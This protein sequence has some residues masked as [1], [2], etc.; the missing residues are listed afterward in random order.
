MPT[1]TD[2]EVEYMG[3]TV[4]LNL[5]S[6]DYYWRIKFPKG[7]LDAHPQAFIIHYIDMSNN[8][9]CILLFCAL[10]AGRSLAYSHYTV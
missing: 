1:E 5:Q 6:R 4:S 7:M 2:Q 3:A 10:H 8:Y 9:V